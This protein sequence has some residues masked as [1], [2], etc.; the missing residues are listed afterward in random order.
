MAKKKAAKK[1]V[2]KKK[3]VKKKAP[4]KKKAPKKKPAKSEAEPTTTSIE[5]PKVV[6]EE[7]FGDDDNDGSEEDT[8]IMS[9]R[10]LAFPIELMGGVVY[11][12]SHMQ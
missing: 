1:K 9:G 5:A 11:A 4:T 2:A 7:N 10:Q 12:S 3:P 6:T 8:S